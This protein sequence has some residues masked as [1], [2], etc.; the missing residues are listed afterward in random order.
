MPAS[1]CRGPCHYSKSVRKAIT[2]LAL[3]DLASRAKVRR[4]ERS[5]KLSNQAIII[6]AGAVILSISFGIR[7]VFGVVLDPISDTY[8]WPR[9]VFS[10]S[11]AIQ[12]M[13]WGLGQPFFGWIADR[14]GDRKAL[15]LGFAAY[16]V[17]ML[18]SVYGSTP[19][20]QHTGAGV[21]VGFGVSGTAFGIILSVVGRATPEEKRSQ[22]LA[23]AAAFGSIG[24]MLMPALTGVLVEMLGWQTALLVITLF[25][26][27]MAMC[28][29]FM[30]AQMVAGNA[31]QSDDLSTPDL[32]KRAFG[33]S[34]YL[35]LTA[36]FF[37]CGFHVAFIGAHFPAFVA[38]VCATPE[39]PATELGALT[40]S[41]VGVA[42]FVGTLIVGQLGARL[43]KPW[44]LSAIYAL[45]ALV[46]FVFISFP[47]TP[48]TVII[49]SVCMGLLWL[50]TVPLTS[51]LVA[52][53][54]GPRHMGTLYGIVF[55]SHQV[56]SFIGI[57][58]GGR[59][60]DLYGN[61]DLIWYASIALGI[62]SAIVHLPVRDRAWSPAPA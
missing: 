55:L 54:F 13:V 33:H 50:T 16:L 4:L 5:M 2:R 34:S 47:F 41:I 19:M 51:G 23:L 18:I 30:K 62:F 45:R 14:F 52:T 28:I 12:N 36:G 29:P 25:L 21:M 10:L 56:G 48:L 53:M 40:L 20:M 15:W 24:Q 60:Y 58:M 38:E 35:L 44:I 3:T 1:P 26:I 61:Y 31:A 43:P 49:F 9:E 46:I 6:A 7:S 42:N 32:L 11:M 27:P 37:V 22:A 57:Y 8:G 39:G 59:V 17:G